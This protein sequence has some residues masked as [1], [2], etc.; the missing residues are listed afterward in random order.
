MSNRVQQYLDAVAQLHAGGVI[1]P[2]SLILFGS[3]ASGA[4]SG[5]S[6]VDLIIVMPDETTQEDRRR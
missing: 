2:M 4:F 5:S 3:A 6:D 1:S